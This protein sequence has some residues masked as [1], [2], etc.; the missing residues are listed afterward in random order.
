M[1]EQFQPRTLFLIDGIGALLSAFLL[2]VLLPQFE[3]YFGITSKSLLILS[4]IAVLFAF[5]SF[6]HYTFLP[7]KWR[8]RLRIIA[9]LN[10]AY[11]VFTVGVVLNL[12][13]EI[14]TLGIVYFSLEILI[15]TLL[16]FFELR[17]ART[18]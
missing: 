8:L 9:L 3:P 13:D 12:R 17:K 11:V 6:F 15:V 18:F 16:A 14:T 5:Y 1:A 2:G 10:L 7:E 4:S